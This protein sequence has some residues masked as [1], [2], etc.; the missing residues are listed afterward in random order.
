MAAANSDK[1]S[2]FWLRLMGLDPRELSRNFDL[3]LSLKVNLRPTPNLPLPLKLTLLLA[4]LPIHKFLP[5]NKQSII[6]KIDRLSIFGVREPKWLAQDD[7]GAFVLAR[8]DD[9]A[10]N[11]VGDSELVLVVNRHLGGVGGG[12]KDLGKGASIRFDGFGG[13][14]VSDLGRGVVAEST[15]EVVAGVDVLKYTKTPV[16]ILLGIIWEGTY[17]D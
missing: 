8:R 9:I 14:G 5:P 13:T 12:V 1:L 11:K 6:L 17:V 3:P 16:K 4:S 10:H 15:L 2:T 7:L